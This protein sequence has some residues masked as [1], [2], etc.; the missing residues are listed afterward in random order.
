MHFNRSADKVYL[1][2]TFDFLTPTTLNITYIYVLDF[3]AASYSTS[4]QIDFFHK[5]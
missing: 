1:L 2:R 5:N 4:S 3:Q